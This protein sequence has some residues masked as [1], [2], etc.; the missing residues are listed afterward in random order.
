LDDRAHAFDRAIRPE[1][2]CIVR[3]ERVLVKAEYDEASTM[4]GQ[5]RNIT[6]EFGPVLGVLEIAPTLVLNF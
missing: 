3:R 6:S 1:W 2:I 4:I 5:R